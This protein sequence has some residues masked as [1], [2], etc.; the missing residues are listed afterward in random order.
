MKCYYYLQNDQD[1][2]T[3]GKSQ[4]E[5]RSGE[6]FKG[7]F[8]LFDALIGY[9]LKTPKRQST[10]S[11]IRNKIIT[12]IFLVML[13]SQGETWEKD[14]SD[15][16]CWRF[17][18]FGVIKNYFRRLNAKEV[19]ITQ[20]NEELVFPAADDSAKIIRK[21]LRIPRTHTETGIH[22]K[23]RISAENLM[24][25]GKSFDLKKQKMTRESRG[26]FGL[27]QKLGKTLMLFKRCHLSSSYRT[28]SSTV[29][30]EKRIISNSTELY[31]CH[32]RNLCRSGDCTRKRIYDF[33]DVGDSRN[34][35]G[36]WTGFTRFT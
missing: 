26:I 33:W 27:M 10:N 30:A 31:W 1:L 21:K 2:L 20:R 12:R 15:Y 23:K 5:R 4:Y 35:S 17:G 6:T 29:R 24:A 3:D 8:I 36:S 22:S 32:E 16:W 13:L 28:E 9:L 34:L 25:I 7:P 18:K 11:S 14:T 19:L